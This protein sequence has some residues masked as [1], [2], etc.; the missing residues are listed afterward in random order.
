MS[1]QAPLQAQT[2]TKPTITPTV[3]GIL[4]RACAC[5]QHTSAGGE[6]EECKKEREGTL[7]RSA[8][9]PSTKIIQTKLT[10]SQPGDSYE[11]EA[12]RLADQV[13]A[14]PAH[15]AVSRTSPRIQRF[16]E[17]PTGQWST[18]PANVD[19][20]LTGS[21]RPLEP[22]LR[23]DMEQRLGY[24]FSQVRVHTNPEA[25]AAASDLQARAFTVGRDIVFGSGEYVPATRGGKQLLAHELVHVIQQGT[26]QPTPGIQRTPLG[27][28]TPTLKCPPKSVLTNESSNTTLGTLVHNIV[29]E[30]Y[31][32]AHQ[33]ALGEE[34]FILIDRGWGEV[35]TKGRSSTS[36]SRLAT[37]DPPVH[38]A[39]AKGAKQGERATG[40]LAQRPDILD[41]QL[42]TVSEIKSCTPEGAQEG[43]NDLVDYFSRLALAPEKV[44]PSGNRRKRN[45][46]T[47]SWR[48]Q[49]FLYAQ[50]NPP[51]QVVFSMPQRGLILYSIWSCQPIDDRKPP[52]PP[53]V[54]DQPFDSKGEPKTTP[55][56]K[57][58]GD[59]QRD[60]GN[61]Q[62]DKGDG[63][64]DK[65]KS[66]R[67]GQKTP[68]E[69]QP[70]L[71][72]PNLPNWLLWVLGAVGVLAILGSIWGKI[73]AAIGAFLAALGFTLGMAAADDKPGGAGGAPKGTTI[74]PPKGTPQPGGT[75]TVPP[76]ST[77]VSPRRTT[78]KKEDQP[79][80]TVQPQKKV[81]QLDL[82]E[83]INLDS[84]AKGMVLPIQISDLK[85]KHEVSIL[86]VTNVVK[87]KGATTVEFKALQ[88]R[89]YDEKTGLSPVVLG[90][91]TYTVTHPAS[92]TGLPKLVGRVVKIGSDGQWFWN[93][94]DNLANKLD[95]AGLKNE[96]NQVRQ[97]IRRQKD[98]FK[99]SPS[100]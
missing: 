24:D 88:E 16:T 100:Q 62:R 44:P 77:G 55:E 22:T 12:D 90:G 78:G 89:R 46:R 69:Q 7:Q 93:Y 29:Q 33:A 18:A 71:R 63:Q 13:I 27:C 6:C 68:P 17:K 1:G 52:D 60:K 48:P 99:G 87:G 70:F 80:G 96:A 74:Q 50:G 64:R 11:Q 19:Q 72:L 47:S 56:T 5:G 94:L 73:G 15:H 59:G 66:D 34:N 25:A 20:A 41:D 14:T 65:G 53:L 91:N 92:G 57:G 36:I 85:S 97:E 8:I 40:T 45:W 37:L 75:T 38:G 84:L 58:K 32:S 79:A 86:Q 21:G 83:G 54:F 39:F 23:R 26:G 4:Q 98:L 42:D 10:I 49:D 35:H 28:G 67:P 81:I 31:L 3:N 61:G 9:T 95:T 82:I 30:R 2:T 51:F 43:R 76:T